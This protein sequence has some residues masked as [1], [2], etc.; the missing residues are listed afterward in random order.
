MQA[1]DQKLLYQLEWP[2]DRIT[3]VGGGV[4]LYV[5]SRLSAVPLS[6]LNKVGFA[7]S[8]WC[9]ISLSDSDKLLVGVVYRA[10]SL[11]QDNNQKL[12]SILREV[13]NTVNFSHLLIMGDFNFPSIDW[14]ECV[15]LSSENSSAFLFLDAIQDSFLTQHVTQCIRH[16]HGQQSSLLD[17]ALSSDPNFID[18][19]TN[20]SALG[21]NNHDCLFGNT[22]VMR[23][24]LSL[25]MIPLN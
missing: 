16:R 14:S 24:V 1:G 10:P 15:C 19:V 4:A 25:G 20:L 11:S 22:S 2:N 12:L 8:M 9:T 18:K 7:N 13:H 6:T 21:S 5:H 17:L 23:S 3:D